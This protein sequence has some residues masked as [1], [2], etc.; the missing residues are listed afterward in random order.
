MKTTEVKVYY[1]K[2]KKKKKALYIKRA[3]DIFLSAM[4]ILITFPVFI[5]ISL[6]FSF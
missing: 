4:L 5:V 2:L 6:N 1:D 3:F